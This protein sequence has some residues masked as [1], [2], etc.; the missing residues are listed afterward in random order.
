MSR[1]PSIFPSHNSQMASLGLGLFT[2][3]LCL[4]WQPHTNT[5]NTHTPSTFLSSFL[6]FLYSLSLGPFRGALYSTALIILLPEL[7]D[8]R[9]F[10]ATCSFNSVLFCCL[11][12]FVVDSSSTRTP[13][14]HPPL[15]GKNYVSARPFFSYAAKRV[16]CF[17]SPRS[18]LAPRVASNP[19]RPPLRTG[20]MDR[21]DV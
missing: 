17:R 3:P 13:I 6:Y 7:G 18:T 12:S 21:Y 16:F 20:C 14:L 8:F 9:W 10:N 19:S 11:V 15:T 4:P 2:L 5:H 1:G